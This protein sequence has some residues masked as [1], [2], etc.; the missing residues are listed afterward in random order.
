VRVAA[1]ADVHAQADA[2]RAVMAAAV[3]AEV[4]ELWS[5]G[6]L[7]GGGPD[8]EQ[9]VA[10]VR[11][12]CRVALAGNHDYGATGSVDATRFGEAGHR[13]VVFAAERLAASGDLDWLR[14][15][16]PAARRAGV[17]CWHAS[18]R[19]P[20]REYVGPANAAACMERQ[21]TAIGLIGHT[22]VPAAWRATADGSVTPVEVRP[23][24]PLDL[25]DGKW[26]LN[27][28]AV[29]RRWR[30]AATGGP[31]WPSTPGPAPGGSSSTSARASRRG[32]APRSTS[33]PRSSGP[34][35]PG[36]RCRRPTRTPLAPAPGSRPGDRPPRRTPA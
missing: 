8:P 25:A 13:S 29:G 23:G 16:R 21:R 27:P 15:R 1:F 31:R 10:L 14:A 3:D 7:V 24:G 11:A 17:Q 34:S 30:P 4:D 18:P 6:D 35:P 36:W 28:G 19:H 26:L 12:Y 22:H 2:L 5:L 20:V 9:V 33:G 32:G